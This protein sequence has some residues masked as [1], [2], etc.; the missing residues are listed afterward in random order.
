MGGNGPAH[1]I[2]PLKTKLGG[3]EFGKTIDRRVE[4]FR[5]ARRPLARE[6]FF[7]VARMPSEW[8]HAVCCAGSFSARP[9]VA[10]F[11]IAQIAGGS[12]L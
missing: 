7:C 9:A 1:R 10:D 3:V 5:S 6:T 11:G 4:R 8:H 12:S 2:A